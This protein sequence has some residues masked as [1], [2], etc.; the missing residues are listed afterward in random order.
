M[1]WTIF[2]LI[3]KLLFLLLFCIGK[4]GEIIFFY[5]L[6]EEELKYNYGKLNSKEFIRGI[7]IPFY[8][9]YYISNKMKNNEN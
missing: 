8:S 3:I 7:F 9:I 1:I 2:F 4:V 6:A 5:T